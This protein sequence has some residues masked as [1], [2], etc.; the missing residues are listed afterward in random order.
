MR[1]CGWKRLRSVERAPVAA[2]ARRQS[3]GYEEDEIHEP[4][5]SQASESEEL[6]DGG[7]RVA[8]T[9]AVHAEAA[10]EERVQERG[11]EVV[12]RVFDAWLVPPQEFPRPGTLDA[13]KRCA[14]HLSV[15][16][17]FVH[18]AL[19]SN[20]HTAV[21]QLLEGRDVSIMINR[22][23]AVYKLLGKVPTEDHR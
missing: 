7:A 21:S 19:I 5:D 8:Q 22:I 9:E 14:Q 13:V 10:Q 6:P 1:T 23:S 3:S 11:D 17:I 2:V 4:P 16:Y 18:L 12:A 20:L 15:I